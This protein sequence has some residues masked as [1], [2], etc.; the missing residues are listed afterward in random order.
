MLNRR[1]L[2]IQSQ[3]PLQAPKRSLPVLHDQAQALHLAERSSKIR[4]EG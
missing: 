4:P 2:S 3:A 1:T